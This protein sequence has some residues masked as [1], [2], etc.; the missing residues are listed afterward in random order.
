MSS[1]EN[2]DTKY[3]QKVCEG[4]KT[5]RQKFILKFSDHAMWVAKKGIEILSQMK[6]T[7]FIKLFLEAQFN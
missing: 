5:S 2:E 3:A 1:I 6:N 7:I 4:E